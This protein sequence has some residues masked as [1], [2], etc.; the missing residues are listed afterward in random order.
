MLTADRATV[1]TIENFQRSFQQF[2]QLHALVLAEIVHFL[3]KE[4]EK[5]I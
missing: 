2:T 1:Q 3:R 5:N 4:K